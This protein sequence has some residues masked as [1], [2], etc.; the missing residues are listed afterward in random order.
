MWPWYLNKHTRSNLCCW[1]QGEIE[2]MKDDWF[3]IWLV[4]WRASA[5]PAC[6]QQP[7]SLGAQ[8]SDGAVQVDCE[9]R[10][11]KEDRV[12]TNYS[13]FVLFDKSGSPRN[14]GGG[15]V[16]VSSCSCSSAIDVRCP[17]KLKFSRLYSRCSNCFNRQV[18]LFRSFNNSHV[19]Q[20]L[21]VLIRNNIT[22]R[23]E[24]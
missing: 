16:T 7:P 19:V 20:L 8:C 4:T 15:F 3:S 24:K 11:E 23:A 1:K 18:F 21:T 6:W 17:D 12:M 13:K 2:L 10:I 9:V 5:W 22:T 14:V